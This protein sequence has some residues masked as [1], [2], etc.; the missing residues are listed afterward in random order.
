VNHTSGQL[1]SAA[2]RPVIEAATPAQAD[3]ADL[4]PLA[5]LLLTLAGDGQPAPVAQAQLADVTCA[6]KGRKRRAP[7]K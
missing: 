7:G 4:A 1:E 6:S 5:R 3:P 2:G